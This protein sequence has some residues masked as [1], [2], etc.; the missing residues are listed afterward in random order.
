VGF[1]NAC[2]FTAGV[3]F[4]IQNYGLP[5]LG[6]AMGAITFRLFIRPDQPAMSCRVQT[7]KARQHDWS[8]LLPVC[9]VSLGISL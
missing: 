7:Q 3:A 5:S 4:A 2:Q 9:R 6:D 1:E 8:N